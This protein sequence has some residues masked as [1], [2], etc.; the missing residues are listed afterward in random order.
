ME[1]PERTLAHAEHD[2]N[3]FVFECVI[4]RDITF[5]VLR[6]CTENFRWWR[7]HN[8]NVTVIVVQLTERKIEKSST[9]TSIIALIDNKRHVTIH[10]LRLLN[11]A[12]CSIK[13]VVYKGEINSSMIWDIR[14]KFQ[15]IE[16]FHAI[17]NAFVYLHISGV[18]ICDK[19]PMNDI[20]IKLFKHNVFV[21]FLVVIRS[22][23]KNRWRRKPTHTE[24]RDHSA[25]FFY[26]PIIFF[27]WLLLTLLITSHRWNTSCPH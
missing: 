17:Q 24:S 3:G 8:G 18:Y 14:A 13:Y 20:Y 7:D 27:F 26:S 10:R 21:N 22:C 4:E 1:M 9:R 16:Q 25:F 5:V 19:A 15:F 11:C 6:I 2:A 12:K 23:K